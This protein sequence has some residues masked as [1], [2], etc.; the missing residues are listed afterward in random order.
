M[1][2]PFDKPGD[3]QGASPN[4]TPANKNWTDHDSMEKNVLLC[5]GREIENYQNNRNPGPKIQNTILSQAHGPVKQ[6][7]SHGIPIL[8]YVP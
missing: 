7:F 2:T 5:E 8:S 3:T 4:L 1:S 6:A